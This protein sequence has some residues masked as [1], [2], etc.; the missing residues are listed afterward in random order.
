MDLVAGTM[1]PLHKLSSS[2]RRVTLTQFI[3]GKMGNGSSYKT[4]SVCSVG[5]LGNIPTSCLGKWSPESRCSGPAMTK[6]G[7]L[8]AV[9]VIVK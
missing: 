1:S 4:K 6:R 7:K 3:K 5:Y 2:V 8:N 9:W